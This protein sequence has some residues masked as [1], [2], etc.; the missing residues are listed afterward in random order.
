MYQPRSRLA[1]YQLLS[2]RSRGER[3][4]ILG[5]QRILERD[6]DISQMFLDQLVGRR[7][8]EA[9]ACYLEKWPAYLRELEAMVRQID[10]AGDKTS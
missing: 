6:R 10:S 1:L 5:T 8:S 3:R 4:I 2:S 9:L 7:F